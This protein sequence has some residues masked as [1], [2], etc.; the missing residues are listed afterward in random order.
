M[1]TSTLISVIFLFLLTSFT[2]KPS[3]KF[4]YLV[5]ITTKFGEIKIILFDDTQIH[6]ANFLDNISKGYYYGTNFHRVIPNFMIQGGAPERKIF[7]DSASFDEMTIPNEIMEKHKHHYGA[8]AAA[9]TENPGKR[10]DKTQ[11]YIVQNKNGAHHLNNAY[12]VFGKVVS[13][14]STVEKITNQP[15]N[16]SSPVE[17]IEMDILSKKVKKSDLIKFYGVGYEE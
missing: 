15:L 1:K 13:G 7:S 10:S 3:E 8:V 17:K 4:D 16:G 9:R 12:T 6:K 2:Y 5:T 14:M 11:F